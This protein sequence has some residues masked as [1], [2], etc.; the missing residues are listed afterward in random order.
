MPFY[1]PK[2][3]ISTARG[4]ERKVR[5]AIFLLRFLGRLVGK[6]WWLVFVLDFFVPL[7]TCRLNCVL[8]NCPH[9]GKK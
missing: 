7:L 8:H 3:F 4:C 9:Q 2:Y 6:K 5:T 1:S